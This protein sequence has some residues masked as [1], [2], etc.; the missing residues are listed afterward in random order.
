VSTETP[1]DVAH[2][3]DPRMTHLLDLALEFSSHT[4]TDEAYSLLM[5][6][7]TLAYTDHLMGQVVN[8]ARFL[9]TNAYFREALS[10]GAVQRGPDAFVF[11]AD[12]LTNIQIER[13]VWWEEHKQSHHMRP[14]AD[15]QATQRAAACA[16][17]YAYRNHHAHDDA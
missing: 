7:S 16:E 1:P 3:D 6:A 15:Q 9:G 14:E 4:L 10:R 17:A 11:L 12:Y 5:A 13:K 8:T 2:R